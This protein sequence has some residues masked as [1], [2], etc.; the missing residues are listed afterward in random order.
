MARLYDKITPNQYAIL[1]LPFFE[2]AGLVAHDVSRYHNNGVLTGPPNWLQLPSGIWVMDCDGA[3]D[4]LRIS[5]NPVWAFGVL[6]FSFV[7]WINLTAPPVNAVLF[8]Q[9]APFSYWNGPDYFYIQRGGN[10]V[11]TPTATSMG[12]TWGAWHQIALTRKN[13]NTW[14]FYL[15]KVPFTM[16]GVT[17]INIPDTGDVMGLGAFPSLPFPTNPMLGKF[18]HPRMYLNYAMPQ[19][20]VTAHFVVER[21][22]YP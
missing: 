3:S 10:N 13:V 14:K 11:V 5:D 6:D 12:F 19:D 20:V 2:G 21:A 7:E 18:S 16:T 9:A 1:D 22:L 17:G 8:A 15:D 4:L